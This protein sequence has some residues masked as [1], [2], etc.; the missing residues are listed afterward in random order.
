MPWSIEDVDQFKS[1]LTDS[2][3]RQWVEVANSALAACL[4]EGKTD[5]DAEAIKQANGVVE[6]AMHEHASLGEKILEAVFDEGTTF[7][8]TIQGFLRAARAV[9]NHPNVPKAVKEKIDGLRTTL[10]ANKWADLETGP[11]PSTAG[12]S[13]ATREALGSIVSE[14]DNGIEES[15]E[16]GA[17][18]ATFI[19]DGVLV[20]IE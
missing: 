13:E 11:T 4:A 9:T 3:K 6:E 2:Q 15:K 5:C 17:L 12:A 20:G 7:K 19:E 8:A 10:A 16:D 18:A 14:S 1:G